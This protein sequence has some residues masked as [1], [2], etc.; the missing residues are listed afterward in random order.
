MLDKPKILFE[1]CFKF[2]KSRRYCYSAE[3]MNELRAIAFFGFY[4]R[5]SY[6][7]YRSFLKQ[8]AKQKVSNSLK[9]IEKWWYRTEAVVTMSFLLCKNV[10]LNY[11]KC[12][13]DRILLKKLQSDLLR[14]CNRFLELSQYMIQ[15]RFR[16]VIVVSE[17]MKKS[18]NEA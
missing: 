4:L 3:T 8:A 5:R 1:E 14:C 7:M 6:L 18:E 13:T 9:M 11:N 17:G 12:E 15:E 2:R 16:S 10:I